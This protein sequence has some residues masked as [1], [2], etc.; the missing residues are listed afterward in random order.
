MPN[1]RRLSVP[2]APRP[3]RVVMLPRSSLLGVHAMLK[4]HIYSAAF[5]EPDFSENL[6][7][8]TTD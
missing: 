2:R 5:A 6:M 3:A 4:Y 7:N 8:K 1:G